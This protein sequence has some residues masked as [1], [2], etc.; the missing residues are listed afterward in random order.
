MQD[1]P[2]QCKSEGSPG[3]DQPGED[4]FGEGLVRLSVNRVNALLC[5]SQKLFKDDKYMEKMLSSLSGDEWKRV[6]NTITP[7]FSASKL[8]VVGVS[9]AQVRNK[10]LNQLNNNDLSNSVK[11]THSFIFFHTDDRKREP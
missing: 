11:V 1:L 5:F 2:S 9:F 4:N 8:K 10:K 6:R 3:H 7:A